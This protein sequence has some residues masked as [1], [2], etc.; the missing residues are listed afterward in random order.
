MLEAPRLLY[1]AS[2]GA[3]VFWVLPLSYLWLTRPGTVLNLAIVFITVIATG[4]LGYV[5]IQRRAAL[6]GMLGQSITDLYGE[7]EPNLACT[8]DR[9]TTTLLV[10]YPDWFFVRQ[11]EY[12]VGHD[13]IVTLSAGGTMSDLYEVNFGRQHL[14]D[15][16]A[17]PDIQP[18]SAAY[19]SMG[20]I[21][22][23]DSL[24]TQIRK[25]GEVI[26]STAR[27]TD[28]DMRFGGCLVTEQQPEPSAYLARFGGGLVLLHTSVAP[29]PQRGEWAVSLDWQAIAPMD[30]DMAISVQLI[31][32]DGKQVAQA[33]GYPL[34]RTS[35]T[36][37]WKAGDVWHDVRYL[38]VKDMQPNGHYRVLVRAYRTNNG[39]H[40][41]AVDGAGERLQDE[42]YVVTP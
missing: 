39:S 12:L 41:T 26:V 33:D 17:V 28:A 36:R 29:D 22:T 1:L 21:Y 32:A 11:P 38:N 34:L 8:Q 37:L 23:P 18:A 10:N 24:Q 42:L 40:V 6:Y 31:G 27:Q 16:A 2:I 30:V 14:F 35:P 4:A 13:S 25:A 19:V 7:V 15:A 9:R 3:A 20:G 5:T